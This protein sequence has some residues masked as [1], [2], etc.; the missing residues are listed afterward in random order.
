MKWKR[1][2]LARGKHAT[3]ERRPLDVLGD[4]F[5]VTGRCTLVTTMQ[6]FKIIGAAR[7]PL[8]ASLFAG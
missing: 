2:L 5:L 3:Q 7:S 4:T 8:A 1:V 6:M